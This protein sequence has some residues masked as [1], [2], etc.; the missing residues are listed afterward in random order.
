MYVVCFI[1]GAGNTFRI[2]KTSKRNE[3]RKRKS[4]PASPDFPKQPLSEFI[5]ESCK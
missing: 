5:V 3:S 1:T 2:P 4:S